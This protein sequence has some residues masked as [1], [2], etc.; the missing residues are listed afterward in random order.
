MALG[1][2][3]RLYLMDGTPTGPIAAEVINWTG[4]LIVVPRPQLHELSSRD[5]LQRTG[6]YLLVGPSDDGRDRIY[7]GEADEVFARLKEHDKDPRKEFWIRAVAITSK[8]QNLTKA[9]GRY[10]ESRLIELATLAGKAEIGNGTSPGTK[11]LPESDRA[12]MEYFLDQVRLTLPVLGFDFLRA[13]P[14]TPLNNST[15][16]PDS[17]K[18]V[19]QEVGAY[20]VAYEIDGQFVVQKG[21]TARRE[22]SK[23]WDTY[24]PV[25]EA[26]ISQRKL[27]PKDD[28]FFEFIEDTEFSSP[29][30]AATI[31]AGGNRNGRTSWKLESTGQTYAEWKESQVDAATGGSDT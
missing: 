13:T 21:S 11:T 31:I 28:Q 22:M 29:S 5:E 19:L 25:R 12:D 7:I 18:L 1:K 30:A 16:T 23:S 20:A 3:I 6:I 9:H 15:S 24:V 17:P 4:Q 26:L 10:L 8:D 14:A 2:T 27:V